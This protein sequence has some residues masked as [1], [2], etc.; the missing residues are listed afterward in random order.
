MTPEELDEAVAHEA[1]RRWRAGGGDPSLV[2][3]LQ[4]VAT[5]SARL[6]REGWVPVD[7]DL[8]AV[9]GVLRDKHPEIAAAWGNKTALWGGEYAEQAVLDAY[10]AGREAE[11]ERAQVVSDALVE[12]LDDYGNWDY[13]D[14]ELRQIID[15]YKAAR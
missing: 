2:R 7:P 13:C 5:I 8:I 4:E 6:A 9:Q 3:S 12:A 11:S 1:E 15:N 14:K 10:K